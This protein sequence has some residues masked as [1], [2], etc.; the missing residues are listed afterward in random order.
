MAKSKSNQT[1][2]FAAIRNLIDCLYITTRMCKAQTLKAEEIINV[3]SDAVLHS[4]KW[5]DTTTRA[6]LHEAEKAVKL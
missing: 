1:G 3:A 6:N 4:A 5:V 2:V